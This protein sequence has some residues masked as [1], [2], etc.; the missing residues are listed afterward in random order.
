MI[1]RMKMVV[2]EYKKTKKKSIIEVD[3]RHYE[4]KYIGKGQFSK[5]YQIGDRVVMYTRGDCAK[6]VLAMY[7]YDRM[8][9]LP[10]LVSHD[11]IVLR[12]RDYD[13]WVFS[14][15][16]YRNVTTR[17]TSAYE[18]MKRIIILF[19]TF[20]KDPDTYNIRRSPY[21]YEIME[22]FIKY[23]KYDR[24]IPRSIIK[25]LYTVYELSRNCGD[26]M[27]FDFKKNNFGVNQY[28]TL[29]FRDVVWVKS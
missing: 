1:R 14:S 8:A 16:F 10:E 19:N 7:Q 3:G 24:Y 15:P 17:D 21:D 26:K 18:L 20:N 4:A 29:I 11:K 6:E 27:G 12:N 9:H 25:A 13:W 5:V 22:A 23:I 28:G 2:G